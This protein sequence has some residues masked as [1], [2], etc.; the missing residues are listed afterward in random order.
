MTV[1][2]SPMP[3][4]QF[5]G[6]NG[7]PLA[8]GYLYTYAPGSPGTIK[9][10]YVDSTGHILNQSPIVLDSA[11]RASIWL[12]GY[13]YMELWTG[14]RTAPGSSVIWSQ[15]NISAR[16]DIID[17]L[18]NVTHIPWVD[19]SFYPTLQ[20]A[21]SA[22]GSVPAMLLIKDI[23][24]VSTNTTVPS[25]VQLWFVQGGRLQISTGIT[26]TINGDVRAGL[27]RIFG[28]NGS[29]VFG[30]NVDAIQPEWFTGGT[31]P[32]ITIAGSPAPRLGERAPLLSPAFT[33]LMSLTQPFKVGSTQVNVTGT[34]LNLL[35]LGTGT[36]GVTGNL[37]F[38]SS[39][40]GTTTSGIVFSDKPVIGF[41][42]SSLT[43]TSAS[44]SSTDS[45][46][47]ANIATTM[48]VTL[49]T[50]STNTGRILHIKTIQAQVVNS[51]SSNIIPLIGG[52][53]G[54]GILTNT[55]GK[56]AILQSD[57]SNWQ[58]MAAN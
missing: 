27:T 40:T 43:T 49:P 14:D 5:F 36:L 33:G 25:N 41:G 9:Y 4:L 24:I 52:S 54:T 13:Y 10:S 12:D 16:V 30:N 28:G 39:S 6:N 26:C 58:I 7:L 3:V 44:V 55:A 31:I 46:L 1:A 20:V 23:T 51:A 42:I 56:W 21:L 29:V 37:V 47:I 19:A 53:A 45:S 48:T 34:Q 35:G 8:G 2:L 22:I 17:Y 11:G 38:A 57:G 18:G 50:A 15:D 32:A